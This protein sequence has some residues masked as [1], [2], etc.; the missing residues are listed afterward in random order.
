MY[1]GWGMGWGVEKMQDSYSIQIELLDVWNIEYTPFAKSVIFED[2]S[3]K[4]N[5]RLYDHVTQ[6]TP[7]R[8]TE[9][10]SKQRG[11]NLLKCIKGR[12]G[13]RRIVLNFCVGF[14]ILVQ[15][16]T[17]LGIDVL[18]PSG[19]FQHPSFYRTPFPVRSRLISISLRTKSVL[20]ILYVLRT[21]FMWHRPGDISL[22]RP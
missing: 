9:Y 10:F 3:L 7:H 11:S 12:S 15:T 16:V 20:S 19:I 21:P 8:K 4:I 5:N 6:V 2:D 22:Q 1:L 14:V 13:H 18:S 17:S